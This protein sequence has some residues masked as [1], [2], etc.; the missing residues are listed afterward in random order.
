MARGRR[1]PQEHR[2]VGDVVGAA[3]LARPGFSLRWKY[4]FRLS[5][6]RPGTWWVSGS[7]PMTPDE[8]TMLPI[9]T[10]I[11]IGHCRGQR[12]APRAR[13]LAHT[14]DMPSAVFLPCRWVAHARR[15]LGCFA[16]SSLRRAGPFIPRAQRVVPQTE[17]ICRLFPR[18]SATRDLRGDPRGGWWRTDWTHAVCA[19]RQRATVARPNL[20]PA[21]ACPPRSATPVAALAPASGSAADWTPGVS[22]CTHPATQ[23]RGDRQG[24][25]EP[26]WPPQRPAESDEQTRGA[27]AED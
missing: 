24:R 27:C 13:S 1:C 11:G 18:A 17:R 23:R 2:H 6:R 15:A 12:Q 8:N 21:T 4:E 5:F 7:R 20:R 10:L 9:L 3:S 22:Q 14:L 26:H 25:C 19:G 16:R